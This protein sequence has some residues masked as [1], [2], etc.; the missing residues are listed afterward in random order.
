MKSIIYNSLF[1]LILFSMIRCKNNTARNVLV[2]T[3]P[4]YDTLFPVIYNYVPANNG[5][6]A[7]RTI[8]SK[9]LQVKLIPNLETR[10]KL[11][12][13]K[14]TNIIGVHQFF[15]D[16]DLVSGFVHPFTQNMFAQLKPDEFVMKYRESV[17]D[18]NIG[19][20]SYMHKSDLTSTDIL[21][22]NIAYFRNWHLS[23]VDYKLKN[24][25]IYV[26]FNTCNFNQRC[27]CPESKKEGNMKQIPVWLTIE[28]G[29]QLIDKLDAFG[30]YDGGTVALIWEVNKE[31]FFQDIHSSWK[32]ILERAIE[33]SNTYHTDPTIAVS[34][35]GPLAH[36]VRADSNFELSV[37]SIDALA[38][39]GKRFGAGYG[40]ILS[41]NAKK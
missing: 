19:N 35:A 37:A 5:D 38:P 33:I 30:S 18:N 13:T 22:K 23:D 29:Y 10:A 36:K 21:G 27:A 15:L 14:L 28:P 25:H 32:E 31:I 26:Y 39:Y 12:L 24:D 2:T 1:V 41:H 3:A 34:D 20:I 16:H 17:E 7:F 9:E 40:Y 8:P 4:C 6:Y 11:K